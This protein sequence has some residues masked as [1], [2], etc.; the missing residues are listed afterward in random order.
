MLFI[1]GDAD[2]TV[3]YQSGRAAYDAAPWPKAFLTLPGGDHGSYLAP[4]DTGFDQMVTASIDFLRATLYRD[5][6]ALARLAADAASGGP[7][8]WE[9][10]L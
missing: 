3:S 9:S 5:P 7:W 10:R 8:K 1:H 2:P 4:K 6:T